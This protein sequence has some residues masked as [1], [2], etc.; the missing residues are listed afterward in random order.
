MS[1]LKIALLLSYICIASFSAAIITPALPQ[2]EHLFALNHGELEWIVSLFLLGYVLG[3]L[4]YGP[5]ANR[6]GR[7]QALRY[8]LILN[9]IGIVLCIIS[10]HTI[11]YAGLLLGRF[12]TALG[13]SVGLVCTFILINELLPEKKARSVLSF[14]TVSFTVGVGIAI[15]V[16][17]LVTE[18][19]DWVNCFWI[20]LVHGFVMLFCS[21]QFSET[22]SEPQSLRPMTILRGY[23]SALKSSRLIIFSLTIALLTVVNYCYSA[24]APLYA[25]DTLILSADKYAYWNLLNTLGM[26]G[27]AFLGAY[28]MQRH[29]AKRVICIG[30]SLM[31]PCLLSLIWIASSSLPHTLWFFITTMFLYLFSGLLFSGASFLAS[32]A[33]PDKASGSGMMSFIN[34]GVATLGV[35]I[36]GYLPFQPILSFTVILCVFFIIVTFLVCCCTHEK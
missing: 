33:I 26:L 10:A 22:L 20:L 9:L 28:L 16:G 34:M 30:L 32:N 31:L 13:S 14:T 36:L 7:L 4:I 17:G 15:T 8:G 12:L 1:Q 24:A 11:N 5:L 19:F 23:A 6:F 35:V 25:H 21:W 18:Y 3:Q 29:T 2:I 27:S